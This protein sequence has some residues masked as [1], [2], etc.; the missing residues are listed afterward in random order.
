MYSKVL[1]ILLFLCLCAGTNLSASENKTIEVVMRQIGHRLLLSS[2]DSTT[3]VLPVK[4]LT[5]QTYEVSFE[6]QIFVEADSMYQI[7]ATELARAGV[8]DFIAELKAC[9]S[10]EVYLSFLYHGSRDSITPCGGRPVPRGCYKVEIT[11]LDNKTRPWVWLLLPLIMLPVATYVLRQRKKQQVSPD[12][13][14]DLLPVGHYRLD[15]VARKLLHPVQNE[16]LS[17][18]ELRLLL[19]L[20]SGIN[21]VQSRDKLMNR[22]WEDGGIMVVSKNLDVLVSKLRKKLANDERIKITSVHGVG[23]TLEIPEKE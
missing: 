6:K 12:N 9:A 2:G 15:P 8:S 17:D 22:I 1:S 21:E 4:K 16:T 14:D 20:L 18:K 11:L 7:A 23:Y 3:R 10:R 19:E 13:Q 5:D